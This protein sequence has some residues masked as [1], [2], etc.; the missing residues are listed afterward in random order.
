[1]PLMLTTP[2]ELYAIQVGIPLGDGSQDVRLMYRGY[3][4]TTPVIVYVN[5]NV[6]EFKWL[7]TTEVVDATDA[8]LID[9][10][11]LAGYANP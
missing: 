6:P 7:D 11:A 4:F 9:S 10:L 5:V 8:A 2:T 1:M 3:Y